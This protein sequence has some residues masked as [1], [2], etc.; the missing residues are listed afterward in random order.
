MLDRT[1]RTVTDDHVV[2]AL[3]ANHELV[4]ARK[5][6]CQQ[7]PCIMRFSAVQA[8]DHASNGL[9]MGGGGMRDVLR[10]HCGRPVVAWALRW[11]AFHWP[12]VKIEV[13]LKAE[14]WPNSGFCVCGVPEMAI[15]ARNSNGAQYSKT[16]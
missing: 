4:L 13:C 14:K 3:L 1:K 12:Q 5:D 8:A 9:R 10:D 7:S 11:W 16:N 2:V 15:F 6:T